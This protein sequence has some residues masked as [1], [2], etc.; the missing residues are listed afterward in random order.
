M[1]SERLLDVVGLA[2]GLLVW[3][4]HALVPWRLRGS[5]STAVGPRRTWS[6]AALP[7][8]LGLFLLTL[9]RVL[10]FPDAALAA[11]LDPLQ[12][13][14]LTARVVLVLVVALFAVDLLLI[15]AGP[16][17]EPAGWLLAAIFGAATLAAVSTA[18]ELLRAGDGLA[19]TPAMLALTA[20]SRA[21]VAVACA[22]L[23]APWSGGRPWFAAFGAIALPIWL[24]A[25]PEPLFR[26]LLADGAGW[27]AA[28]AVGLF[29]AS[30]VLPG[31]WR[32]VSLAL[33][34]LSCSLLFTLATARAT[35]VLPSLFE[36][37]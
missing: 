9:L 5:Q 6:L 7:L 10:R 27:T 14:G 2:M 21:A 30:L 3:G 37:V 13:G 1:S 26:E 29:C 33:A 34:L 20:A 31:S 24:V 12:D 17:L 16:K 22:E 28:A 18:G 11:R 4:A 36:R 15:V 32:R 23:I 19:S 8:L 25:L 35:N